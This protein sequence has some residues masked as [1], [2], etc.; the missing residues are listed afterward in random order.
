MAQKKYV[1][2]SKLS[3]FLDN[4]KESF[5]ALSHKHTLSD[6]TD[7]EVDTELSSTSTNPVANNALNSEF[8]AVADAMSALETAIDGK[9]DSSHTHTQAS[10]GQGMGCCSTASSTAAKVASLL[11]FKLVEGGVVSVEFVYSVPAAATLDINSTGA[12]DI[13][14]RGEAITENIIKGA[15]RATFIYYNYRYHLISVDRWYEDITD[16][17]ANDEK[18]RQ[19]AVSSNSNYPLLL[20]NYFQDETTTGFT[21]FDSGVYLNPSTNKIYADI[22]GNAA[23]LTNLEATI[24]ELNHMTG[25]TSNVQEQL[26]SLDNS[27]LLNSMNVSL[28]VEGNWLKVCYGGGKF[29]AIATSGEVAYSENGFDWTQATLPASGVW[30]G[31]AYGDGK[32]VVAG[33]NGTTA[34]YSTDGINWSAST[35]PAA[36]YWYA[37]A[38]GNGRFVVISSSSGNENSVAYSVDGINW[39][40]SSLPTTYMQTVT[41]G[42]GMFVALAYRGSLG[43]YSINGRDWIATNVPID[44][45]WCDVAYG[46]GRFV[47]AINGSNIAIY[48]DDGINWTQTE[49]PISANW[50]RIAYGNGTFVAIADDSAVAAYST[51]GINWIQTNMPSQELW[52]GIEYGNGVFVAIVRQGTSVAI[53]YDGVN[54]SNGASTLKDLNGS[55]VSANIRGALGILNMEFITVDDIDSI[56]GSTISVASLSEVTF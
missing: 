40:I 2:L 7:Y 21:Y 17:K 41:Y 51:D 24:D 34:I 53:S 35:L 9:S 11:N 33:Y 15:D 49:M 10:L 12:R 43:A 44:D 6:I 31:I 25:A 26:D 48:S 16:L 54:W 55:D 38:Y 14:Y 27:V 45:D 50:G 13:Y 32:F 42:N 46:S 39:D 56:C 18:V 52:R 20:A 36:E 47:S 4:L 8:D 23:G 28:P 3:T 37:V 22:S 5:A 19:V 1:S 29:V 30:R